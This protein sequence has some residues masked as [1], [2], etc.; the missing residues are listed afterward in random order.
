R[1]RALDLAQVIGG[2]DEIGDVGGEIRV[3]ELA[4]AR[5]E[6]GEVKAQH[7]NAARDQPVGDAFGRVNVL[8]AGEAVG[9]QREGTRRAGWAV[10]ERGEALARCVREV[11]TV[12]R[13]EVLLILLFTGLFASGAAGPGS[14]ALRRGWVPCALG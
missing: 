4:L 2:G 10:Q 3:G 5:A 6:T 14:V 11:E 8:A 7:G 9:E 1:G 12:R 13:H